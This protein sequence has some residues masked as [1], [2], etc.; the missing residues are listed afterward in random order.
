MKSIFLTIVNEL[1]NESDREFLIELYQSHY[2]IVYRKIRAIIGDKAEVEDL[3][4]ECFIRL[5]KKISVLRSL[6]CNILTGYVVITS[7]NL[8]VNYLKHRRVQ[9]QHIY[10]DIEDDPASNLQ[11]PGIGAEELIEHQENVEE[12]SHAINQL[13]ERQRTM[14]YLKYILDLSDN[15]IAQLLGISPDSVRVYLHRARQQAR[16][17]LREER[18]KDE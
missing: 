11:D 6:K 14:L 4:Q 12:V 8:A 15:E 17:I 1:H 9:D 3:C 2:D 16:A 10:Y 7:K 5:I 13:P 18:F